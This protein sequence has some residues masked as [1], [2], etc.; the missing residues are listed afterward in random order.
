MFRTFHDL[1]VQA[2][3]YEMKAEEALGHR[4]DED[5]CAYYNRLAADARRRFRR[6][7]RHVRQQASLN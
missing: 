5:E 6:L 4:A 2:L 3:A 7:V 1:Y